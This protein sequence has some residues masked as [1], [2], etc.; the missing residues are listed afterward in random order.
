MAYDG[1]DGNDCVYS[2]GGMSAVY[3]MEPGTD[4]W[5]HNSACPAT[6]DNYLSAGWCGSYAPENV[7]DCG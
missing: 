6:F 2:S 4:L 5:G 3:D 1:D 7:I